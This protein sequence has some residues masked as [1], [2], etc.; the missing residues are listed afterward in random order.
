MTA[1]DELES[2]DLQSVLVS[3]V[4]LFVESASCIMVILVEYDSSNERGTGLPPFIPHQLVNID[5]RTFVSYVNGHRERLE[6][7]LS[8]VDI[9]H[10]ADNLTHLQPAYRE[11]TVFKAAVNASASFMD[12][13]RCWEV[14]SGQFT[15]LRRFSGGLA[16]TFPNTATVE[17]DF[18]VLGWEK[19]DY[20]TALTNLS[21]ESILHCKQY[22][23][24]K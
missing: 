24:M 17:S 4:K 1:I 7:T 6:R 5:M 19:D 20:R 10:I 12:F 21:L 15:D 13:P 8:A 3:V 14:T 11:E 23:R 2:D 16:T 18:S 9:N 22:K